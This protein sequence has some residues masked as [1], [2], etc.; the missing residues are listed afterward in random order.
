MQYDN[1][2]TPATSKFGSDVCSVSSNCVF[3]LLVCLYL[4]T[5]FFDRW[6]HQVKRTAINR[7][8]IIWWSSVGEEVFYSSMS[9]S[10]SFSETVPLN[11]RLHMCFCFFPHLWWDRMESGLVYFLF[12]TW[13]ASAL[14]TGYFPS[15]RSVRL[16]LNSIPEGGPSQEQNTLM[17]FKMVS[18]S[19]ARSTGEF[20]FCER[21]PLRTWL[22]SQ[23]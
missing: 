2:N 19:F 13:K 9:R 6:I 22:S 1:S 20:F 4:F 3:W 16:Q 14:G 11:Y 5:Y 18:P 8:L 12:S 23:R 7:S 17:S 21:K 10:Y 15:L